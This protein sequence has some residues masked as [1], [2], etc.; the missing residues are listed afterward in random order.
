[1]IILGLLFA[2]V[3]QAAAARTLDR[4]VLALYDS[5]Y[6]ETPAHTMFHQNAEMPLNHL[7]YIVR[8][9]DMRQGLPDEAAL[10]GVVAL[11]SMLIYKFDNAD[12]YFRWL[13]RNAERI[14]RLIFFGDF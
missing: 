4:T 14:P 12:A 6:E 7:G 5:A 8:Y 9:H 1:A 10:D 11:A 3:W 13:E 2:A